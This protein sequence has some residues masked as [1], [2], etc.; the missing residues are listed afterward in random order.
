VARITDADEI[1]VEVCRILD[2]PES[3]GKMVRAAAEVLATHRGATQRNCELVEE[4][5]GP[6]SPEKPQA[7]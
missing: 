1:A 7:R 5:L 6:Q 2:H 4:I 3:V